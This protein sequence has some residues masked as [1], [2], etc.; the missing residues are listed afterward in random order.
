MN[1]AVNRASVALTARRLIVRLLTLVLVVSTLSIITPQ[2]A[3]A[4]TVTA[5]GSNASFC[6]QT[7]DVITGVTAERL[8]NGDCVV[9]FSTAS[10]NISWT[11]PLGVTAVNLLVVAGGGGGGSRHAGGGGG[12]GVLYVTN[13][14]VT[15]SNSVAL[16]VGAG[17]SGAAGGARCAA[18]RPRARL[19]CAR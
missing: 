17:G 9:K 4:A 8:A 7:V 12:G 5:T 2:V 18:P 3:E 14:S 1:L 6:N 13:Y 11:V 15:P 19:P 10:T 16:R